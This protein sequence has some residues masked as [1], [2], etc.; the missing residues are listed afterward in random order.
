MSAQLFTPAIDRLQETT[1]QL[2]Q[3]TDHLWLAYDERGN[4]KSYN[5][6]PLRAAYAL[7]ALAFEVV[8]NDFPSPDAA[9]RSRR[10]SVQWMMDAAMRALAS[11]DELHNLVYD[12][13]VPCDDAVLEIVARASISHAGFSDMPL[14]FGSDV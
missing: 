4:G 14:R 2:R 9:G 5:A 1:F 8:A 11:A 10:P 13:W 3:E 12:T 7:T 6:Y